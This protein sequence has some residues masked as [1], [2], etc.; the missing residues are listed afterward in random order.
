MFEDLRVSAFLAARATQ[1]GGRGRI[2]MNIVII[3]L[4]LTNMIFM[5]SIISGAIEVFNQ[6]NVDYITSDIIIADFDGLGEGKSTSYETAAA[7]H[8]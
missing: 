8:D 1:R 6:Q 5:P 7:T 2:F 3:A 4:V